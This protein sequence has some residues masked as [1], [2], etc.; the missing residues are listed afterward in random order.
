MGQRDDRR[1]ED[2][3]TGLRAIER[4]RPDEGPI[5]SLFTSEGFIPADDAEVATAEALRPDPAALEAAALLDERELQA[6]LAGEPLPGGDAT[7]AVDLPLEL[8]ASI[9]TRRISPS[10][11]C[12][13]PSRCR[14]APSRCPSRIRRSTPWS[15]TW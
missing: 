2:G 1:E 13:I 6:L 4:P 3:A 5:R 8:L 14:C 12:R 9:P 7:A 15:C 11:S 10:A